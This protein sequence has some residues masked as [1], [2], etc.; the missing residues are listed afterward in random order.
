MAIYDDVA[1]WVG[2]IDLTE[3]S[4]YLQLLK[5]LPYT[6]WVATLLDMYQSWGVIAKGAEIAVHVAPGLIRGESL[7]DAIIAD[8]GARLCIVAGVKIGAVLA[9]ASATASA[10]LATYGASAAGVTGALA[11]IEGTKLCTDVLR[12]IKEA[13]EKELGS[14]KANAIAEEG[15]RAVDQ[16]F[17][18]AYA[19]LVTD[20]ALVDLYR[21]PRVRAAL[22]FTRSKEKVLDSFGLGPEAIGERF[23][24]RHDVA[25]LAINTVLHDRIYG[26]NARAF[27]VI[28]GQRRAPLTIPTSDQD[29]ADVMLG[30]ARVRTVAEAE[31]ALLEAERAWSAAITRE[32]QLRARGRDATQAAAETAAFGRRVERQHMLLEQIR[33]RQE[34]ERNANAR[35]LERTAIEARER[36]NQNLESARRG[37]FTVAPSRIG[38]RGIFTLGAGAGALYLGYRYF[39]G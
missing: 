2:D 15:E 14:Q 21:S 23:G 35:I 8:Y 27:D 10:I 12:K 3:P 19:R 1:E 38:L 30:P 6:G 18:R 28:T 33:R 36:A 9:G 20:R 17:N 24:V 34:E 22:T 37:G 39:R 32:Q 16:E 5:V 31:A 11:G 7:S 26:V 13:A 25:A 4:T 29:P